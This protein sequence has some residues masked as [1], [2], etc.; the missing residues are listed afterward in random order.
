MDNDNNNKLK[1]NNAY[2]YIASPNLM[3]ESAEYDLLYKEA[4]YGENESF[5]EYCENTSSYD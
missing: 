4:F 3:F 2:F 1:N 5:C